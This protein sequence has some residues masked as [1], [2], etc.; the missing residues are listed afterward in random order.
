MTVY[1]DSYGDDEY[2][3]DDEDSPADWHY[4]APGE[5]LA[6]YV[7]KYDTWYN[8]TTHLWECGCEVYVVS[9]RCKH[10][11]RFRGQVTVEVNEDYL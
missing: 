10:V 7:R 1:Q 11:Y 5:E 2:S 9:G 6:V 8:F 4:G 3:Y